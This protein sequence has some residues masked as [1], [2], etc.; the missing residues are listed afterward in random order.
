[1]LK[2]IIFFFEKVSLITFKFAY[3]IFKKILILKGNREKVYYVLYESFARDFLPRLLIGI[4]LANKG[5]HVIFIGIREFFKIYD[6][7]PEGIILSKGITANINDQN[8]KIHKRNH[9]HCVLDE[10]QL[11][12]KTK[13]DLIKNLRVDKQIINRVDRYYC[14]GINQREAI[15]EKYPLMKDRAI[16]T[17]SPKFDFLTDNNLN[18][19]NQP[20]IEEI[21]NKYGRYILFPSN[22]GIATY[23]P[24]RAQHTINKTIEDFKITNKKFFSDYNGFLEYKKNSLKE[25]VELIYKI[26][27]KFVDLSLVIRPHPNDDHEFWAK[28][29]K[30]SDKIQLSYKYSIHPWIQG[31]ICSVHNNCTTS[32][33]S[34]FLDK[35]SICFSP[36]SNNSNLQ[37][38]TFKT[39]YEANTHDEVIKNILNI[40]NK[41]N[42]KISKSDDF[43]NSLSNK[44]GVLASKKVSE[45]LSGINCKKFKIIENIF[46]IKYA[47]ILSFIFFGFLNSFRNKYK[48][49]NIKTKIDFDYK[50]KF[51]R[52]EKIICNRNQLK[53]SKITNEFFYIK[54]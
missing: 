11:A 32:V 4:D 1:M 39:S 9:K 17:G 23:S 43:K 54:L 42:I 28:N 34:Y 26:N 30:L 31:S 7:L 53:I 48:V 10:E 14:W 19:I 6:Y 16:V 47:N 5:H 46:A 29:L 20:E 50:K 8:N 40:I 41:K 27:E 22:F 49:R 21:K 35:P 15:I 2:K 36:F 45:D 51:N 24:S 44:K 12:L 37:S 25:F 38:L 18:S 13:N 52:I 33:E 3:F